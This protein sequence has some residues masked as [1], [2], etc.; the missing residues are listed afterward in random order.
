[1]NLEEKISELRMDGQEHLVEELLEKI[2]SQV[3][4]GVQKEKILRGQRNIIAKMRLV[5]LL[6]K[7]LEIGN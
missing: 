3:L 7:K 6:R 2:H 4:N 1:M 5:N